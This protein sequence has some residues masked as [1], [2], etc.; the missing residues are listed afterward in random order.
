MSVRDDMKLLRRVHGKTVPHIKQIVHIRRVLTK[1]ERVLFR[2]STLCFILGVV[3]G[4][5][6][7]AGKYRITVPAPGGRYTEAVVGAPQLINPVFASIND[8][9]KDIVRLV[10]SGLLRYD[11]SERLVPD[12]AARYEVSEDK[13]TYTFSLKKDVHWQDGE[14]FTARDVLFTIET[15][16]NPAVGSPLLVSFQGV[17]VTSPDEYTVVFT[18]KEPFAPFLSTLTVGMIPEHAWFD[19][20]P[21]RMRLAQLNLQPIGTGPFEFKKLLKDDVGN[22]YQYELR[23]SNRYYGTLA[24]LEELVF[25]FYHEY[26]GQTGAIQA[27]REQQVDGINFVPYHVRGQVERKHISLHTLQLPQ[28]TAL[29]FNTDSPVVQKAEVRIAL[30]ESLDKE[31]ILRESLKNEGQVI[32]S[33]ILQGFPGYISDATSTPYAVD[34]A[35]K[36]LDGIWGRISAEE[37]RASRKEDLLKE[38]YEVNVSSTLAVPSSTDA[39]VATTTP[40]EADI[41]TQLDSEVSEAQTFYRKAKEGGVVTLSLVTADTTEYRQIAQSIAGYW[42]EVGIKTQVTFV[43]PKDFSRDVLKGRKY[44]VLLYGVIIGSDPDQY[45]FWHS[46]QIDFPGLNLSRYV[47]RTVDTMLQKAR[48]TTNPEEEAKLY[49]QFQDAIAKDRPAIFLYTPTYTYATTDKIKGI[50]ITRIFHPSD[51]FADVTTWYMKTDTDWRLR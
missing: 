26:E 15:I 37:H 47:N 2:L 20:A 4:G 18:L 28:Y 38:W 12:L 42:Q 30:A 21:E 34:A 40:P 17:T 5:W 10:F 31:R 44:D 43:S 25:K 39:V 29:F 6:V 8:V 49:R 9:D 23:R 1:Q 33:P 22:I 48:E 11:E 24:Y 35:N 14:P 7:Y 36:V 51:R 46:T 45:P 3:W 27:L 13:K 41:D 16:Q 19:I 50:D 32:N